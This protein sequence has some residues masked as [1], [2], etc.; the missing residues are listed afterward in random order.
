MSKSG[1]IV[2]AVD[3][4]TTKVVVVAGRKNEAGKIEIL[5][6]GKAR[7]MGVKRGVVL[8]IDEAFS[9]IHEAIRQAE[10]AFQGD[11]EE[12]YVNIVGQQ[13]KTLT[14]KG[15]RY[16][17]E[18][19]IVSEE[20]VDALFQQVKKVDLPAGYK[21]YHTSPLLFTIDHEAG[22]PN[23]VGMAGEKMQ[24]DFKLLVA[25]EVYEENLK[26]CFERAGITIRKTMIDPLASSEMLLSEDEK[27]AGVVL[28]DIGGGT[29]K[30]AVYRDGVLCYSALIP[31]GGNVITH[32]IKEG[33]TILARQ[34]ESLKVQFGQA[35]GDFAPEDKVVTIPGI[36]GWEPKEISFKSLAFI[37]QARMEEIIEA[38]FFQLEKSGYM[39]QVGAGIV[40]T[41]GSALMPNLGQLI[42]FQTGLDVRKGIPRLKLGDQYK[43]LEDPRNATVLGLLQMALNE[44]EQEPTKEFF[45]KAKKKKVRSTQPGFFSQMKKEVTRQVTLFFDDEQDTEMF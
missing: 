9:A 32:D 43:E 20:D 24:A 15:E 5:G 36:S 14:N 18:R 27:E 8:N 37:I 6:Y 28:L 29:T 3:V 26:L 16:I 38:F 33:C 12:V 42:K 40:L 1:K 45:F 44:T 21:I 10:D 13:L 4:G 35:M 25:P 23:P 41:G 30:M 34:A 19:R 17:G 22:I 31:F 11:I 2:A 39:D 7:S